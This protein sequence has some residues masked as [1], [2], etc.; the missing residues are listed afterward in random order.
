MA[1]KQDEIKEAKERVEDARIALIDTYLAQIRSGYLSSSNEHFRSAV[2]NRLE[3]FV[4]D[5]EDG[6]IIGS[7]LG[8]SMRKNWSF[9]SKE[10]RNVRKRA[11]L[12]MVDLAQKLL[13]QKLGTSVSQPSIINMIYR[14]E[15][16]K[17]KPRN[18]PKGKIAKPYYDWLKEQGYNPYDL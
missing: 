4:E 3:F 10:A 11:G 2:E 7:V 16:G 6:S 13:A 17:I 12:T 9:D 8:K 18:P 5:M 1:E 14:Y 15:N